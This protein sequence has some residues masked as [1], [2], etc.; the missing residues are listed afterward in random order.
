MS[1]YRKVL[2]LKQQEY[3]FCHNDKNLS[4]IVTVEIECG[5]ATLFVSLTNFRSLSS[6]EYH[7]SLLDG[8]GKFFSF[9]LPNRPTSLQRTFNAPVNFDKGFQAGV[10]FV[11]E[12]LPLLVAFGADS[13]QTVSQSIM[14]KK[15]AEKCMLDKKEKEKTLDEYESLS[16]SESGCNL[17]SDYNDEAVA[18]ENYFELEKDIDYKIKL[19][20]EKDY[21]KLRN[22]DEMFTSSN[23]KQA[24]A[25]QKIPD[26]NEDET[27]A[28]SCKKYSAS[29]P[30]Y[31][32]AKSEL[33]EI[34]CK[35]KEDTALCS[36]FHDSKWA[37]IYYS[38]DKYYVVGVIN[39]NK[40]PKYICYGI[41]A[42]YSEH[43]PPELDGYCSFVPLS[44]F[45][46]KGKGYW[47]MYQ[48][49]ITGKRINKYRP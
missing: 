36:L 17:S 40:K 10:Y 43:A 20:G 15:I 45:D 38:A 41:P 16:F 14:R 22:E 12:D 19:L 28:C 1:F 25:E 23:E 13:C 29:N 34:F 33:N 46:V 49:A 3:G 37:Q 7:F 21:E 4:G 39:K 8:D 9:P 24:Q 18:T 44:V 11:L 5:V 27:N 47:M 30:Y 31:E 6:G 32:Y 2:V 26:C 35:F 48:D 42:N